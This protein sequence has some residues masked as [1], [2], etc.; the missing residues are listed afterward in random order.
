MD[1]RRLKLSLML[2]IMLLVIAVN[3]QAGFTW[4]EP[5]GTVTDSIGNPTYQ[6]RAVDGAT[7]YQLYVGADNASYLPTVFYDTIPASV[8][9]AGGVC[10]IDLTTLSSMAWLPNG[11][12]AVFVNPLPMNEWY[13]PSTFE[14][15]APQPTVPVNLSVTNNTI[16][17]TLDGSAGNAAFFQLYV[18]P[19]DNPSLPV[20]GGNL[21]LSRQDVCGRWDGVICAYTLPQPLQS[22]LAYGLYM[23]SWGAGGFSTGGNL[24]L[25]DAWVECMFTMPNG[26]CTERPTESS[27][28]AAL[29]N[30]GLPNLSWTASQHATSYEVWFGRDV[31]T[32]YHAI[33]PAVSLGCAQGGTCTL[34]V[35]IEFPGGLYQWYVRARGEGGI[36]RNDLMGWVQGPDFEIMSTARSIYLQGQQRGNRA[37]VFSKVGDSI[38]DTPYFLRQF[39]TSYDLRDY[40]YLQGALDYF[41]VVQARAGNSFVNDSLAAKSGW[42]TFD[43]LNPAQADEGCLAGETP[44]AC[45][46]RLVRPALALIM[47]G[48]NDLELYSVNQYRANLTQIVQYTIDQGIIPVLSTLPPRA[49]YDAQVTAFNSVIL[50]LAQTYDIPYWDF[51]A[52]VIGLSN[53]GLDWDGVHLSIPPNAPASTH[54]FHCR[55]S[56]LWHNHAQP[57]GTPDAG[58]DLALCVVLIRSRYV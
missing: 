2:P 36:P 44:L 29:P 39:A 30:N 12:Y 46:Y 55:P 41:S 1:I 48:T 43:L 24:P 10:A 35:A 50:D 42:T 52:E 9:G 34:N 18:A 3:G 56:A 15:N 7:A 28:L 21:W 31:P 16:N 19:A 4:L 25:F 27:N 32:S 26:V 8:C 33:I 17:W 54:R 5:T 23:Q 57:A 49:L 11:S 38:T 47:I 51:H 58:Y 14:V 22:D 40:S 45:E 37:N 53:R 20:T 13:G 6:W